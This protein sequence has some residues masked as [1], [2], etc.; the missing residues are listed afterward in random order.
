VATVSVLRKT[1][2]HF[3]ISHGTIDMGVAKKRVG[4][5]MAA[6]AAIVGLS[7]ETVA[8]DDELYYQLGGGEPITRP[9]SNRS[10]TLKLG[11]GAQWSADLMCGNFDMSLSVSEQLNGVKG[12]FSDLMGNVINSAT[13]AVASLPALVIQK[14]NPALYDLLQNGVLQASKEFQIAKTSCEEVVQAMD[15]YSQG[16]GWGAIAKSG[17]WVQQSQDSANEILEVKGASGGA[18]L[19]A[20]VTW[21]G[22]QLRGGKNQAAIEVIGDTVKAGY[23]TLLNRAPSTTTPMGVT[24]AGAGLCDVWDS[25]QDQAD[26]V[27]D[28]LGEQAVRTC[29][30]CDKIETKAGMGLAKKIEEEQ[31]QIETDLIDLVAS[32]APPT[33]AELDAVSGGPGLAMSRRVVEAIQEE[34]AQ[35]QGAL[36]LRIA[37]E[38]ALNRTMERAL[39][40]R[41]SLLAGMKEPNIANVGIAQDTLEKAVDELNTEISNLLFEMEVRNSIA[42]NTA[43]VLLRRN[44]MRKKVPVGENQAPRSFD[45]GAVES[46]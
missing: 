11:I 41:R 27:I 30:G 12:A 24:C 20:G 46:R 29:V 21:S 43:A 22:G 18:G 45:D 26:W 16:N 5:I 14:I 32:N 36:V 7:S 37:G 2:R 39:M 10:S 31:E 23:N 28:V 40:A 34:N 6:C 3:D 1:G 38:M 15:S 8:L 17:Y 33:A 4:K 13:G 25:P 42:T 9:P 35:E 44:L 19:D